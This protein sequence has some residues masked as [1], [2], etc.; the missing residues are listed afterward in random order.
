MSY[1]LA[2]QFAPLDHRSKWS[3]SWGVH[4]TVPAARIKAKREHRV[5]LSSRALEILDR[6]KLLGGEGA[7][8]FP[9]RSAQRPMS[10][11]VFLMA[12]RRMEMPITAHGF[13]ATFRDWAAETTNIPREVAEAALAHQVE[14]KV[15]AAY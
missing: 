14:N 15:E 3:A 2:H 5:P 13:R 4:W 6:A 10:N 1:T 12:L 11:M 7:F 9:G 8:V